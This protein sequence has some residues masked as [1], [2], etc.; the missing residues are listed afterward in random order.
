[1]SHTIWR[2]LYLVVPIALILGF[3]FRPTP[4]LGVDGES[5]AAS[6][7][8]PVNEID[9]VPC[10]QKGESAGGDIWQCTFPGTPAD[11]EDDPPP[12][13]STY[14]LTVDRLGCWTVES[15]KGPKAPP[16]TEGCVTMADHVSSID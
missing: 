13:P 10:T 4:I 1:M 15:A 5:L 16:E 14:S 8:A 2:V 3:V 7:G 6:T 12:V 9:S 11:D